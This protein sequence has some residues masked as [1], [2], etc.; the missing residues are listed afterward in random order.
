MALRHVLA[1]ELQ[2][3][4]LQTPPPGSKRSS[5]QAMA[6]PGNLIL[7]LA[8]VARLATPAWGAENATTTA[9]AGSGVA[10]TTAAPEG[11]TTAG[12]DTGLADGAVGVTGWSG[13]APVLA[14]V[15]VSVS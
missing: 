13:L 10:E 1:L 11:N 4:P 9:A 6:R 12:N 5:V 14:L 3:L 7:A 2:A 8:L 15:A